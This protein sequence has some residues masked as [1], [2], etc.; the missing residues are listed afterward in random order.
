MLR[1]FLPLVLAAL[2]AGATADEAQAQLTY[3]PGGTIS[4]GVRLYP[5]MSTVP[6]YAYYPTFYPYN[7]G[8][9]YYGSYYGYP[10][11]STPYYNRFYTPQLWYGSHYTPYGGY[12][13]YRFR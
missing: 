12:Y 13:W 9:F 2:L 1:K 5:Q 7:Y 10:G 3:Y 4:P 8:S 6:R 11:L